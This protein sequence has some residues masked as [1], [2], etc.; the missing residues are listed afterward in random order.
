[1]SDAAFCHVIEHH[2]RHV[3]YDVPTGRLLRVDEVLAAVLPLFGRCNRDAVIAGLAGRFGA[4]PVGAAIAEIEDARR[5]EGLFLAPRTPAAAPGWSDA[6]ERAFT[7]GRRQLILEVSEDC[8]LRCRY[9]P[10][11]T[12][13][14]QR[15]HRRRTMPFALARV[16]VDEFLEASVETDR[17]HISFYGGEPLLALHAIER[18]VDHVRRRPGGDRVVFGVYT[19]GLRLDDP[20]VAALI[21]R[22]AMVL[23]V[24]IDGPAAIHDRERRTARGAATHA[25][26]EANLTR[27]LRQEPQ[28]AERLVLV[29]TLAPPYDLAA[30]GAYFA[31]FPPFVSAGLDGAPTVRINRTAGDP[32]W[33]SQ[34][35]PMRER[36]LVWRRGG[37]PPADHRVL[38]ALFD[39]AVLAWHH[40]PAGPLAPLVGRGGC[41]RAGV[42]R[43]YVSADGDLQPC[44]RAGGSCWLGSVGGGLQRGE[45]ETLERRFAD[46]FG[47]AC[48]SCWAVRT[49]RMCYADLSRADA[50]ARSE[51][52]RAV[53]EGA[54]AALRLYLDLFFEGSQ[55]AQWLAKTSL[56]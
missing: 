2:G 18:V 28:L 32:A 49:C 15:P 56:V 26:V 4:G 50:R 13:V 55:A 19:N 53:R 27:L 41:C 12:A 21:R 38:Q 23:Q 11:T 5:Q 54:E 52:C 43:L 3:V 25:R 1:M 14:G 24:S 47:A 8:N 9:C 6:D 46:T 36:Y 16:A 48:S 33:R 40:R 10:H 35:T 34:L 7:R 39:D 31:A 30:V 37:P 44:E 45:V 20:R 42:R 17:P 51:R 29:A 22:E